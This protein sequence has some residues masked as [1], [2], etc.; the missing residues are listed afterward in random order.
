VI[1]RCEGVEEF[2]AAWGVEV[3]SED[4]FAQGG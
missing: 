2:V 3:A 4:Q 1:L